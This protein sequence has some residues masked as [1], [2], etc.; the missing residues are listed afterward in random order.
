MRG[1]IELSRTRNLSNTYLFV[2]D[3]GTLEVGT[4]VN[5]GVRLRL[6]DYDLDLSGKVF[7]KGSTDTA[8]VDAFVRQLNAFA[9]TVSGRRNP[10][11]TGL[12]GRRSIELVE[13]CYANRKALTQPWLV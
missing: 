11:V 12:D 6:K 2:G 9:D 3:R 7:F 8:M 1:R 13:T 10:V 5:P 4:S